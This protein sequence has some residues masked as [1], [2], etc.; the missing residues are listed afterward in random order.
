M[1]V[2]AKIPR[3]VLH[4]EGFRIYGRETKQPPRDIPFTL[5]AHFKDSL[6]DGTYREGYLQQLFG[7][8]F[9]EIA[10]T[11]REL[12]WLPDDTLDAIGPLMVQD[13]DIKWS[14][15]KKVDQIKIALRAKSPCQ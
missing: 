13:Y 5:Y 4:L 1:L 3:G 15:K 11:Y 9:P 6:T 12:R 7:H 8:V 14:H 10:F 2:H